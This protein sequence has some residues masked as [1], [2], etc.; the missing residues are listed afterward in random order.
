MALPPGAGEELARRVLNRANSRANL[1]DYVGVRQATCGD[2][3]A[4][5]RGDLF[6]EYGG[7]GQDAEA[8]RVVAMVNAAADER[9]DPDLG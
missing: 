2:G 1:D 7:N 9:A 5:I 6:A 4:D 3:A 8:E